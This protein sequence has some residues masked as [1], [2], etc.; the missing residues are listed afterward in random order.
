VY[1][2]IDPMEYPLNKTESNGNS[3][4]EEDTEF[5]V[6]NGISAHWRYNLHYEKAPI[7]VV[8]VGPLFKSDSKFDAHC[9]WP[10]FD[11]AILA[12]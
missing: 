2:I 12:K 10:S 8:V 7:V 11:D 1:Q 9:G 3:G 6:R 4:E 5:C